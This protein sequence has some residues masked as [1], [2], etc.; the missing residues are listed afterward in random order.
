MYI[1][2]QMDDKSIK[3]DIPQSGSFLEGGVDLGI[4]EVF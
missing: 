1:E 2:M 3:N 4:L